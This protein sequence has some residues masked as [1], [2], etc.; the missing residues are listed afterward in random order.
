MT[1]ATQPSERGPEVSGP[2]LASSSVND[3]SGLR[4]EFD[5]ARSAFPDLGPRLDKACSRRLEMAQATLEELE[6]RL[7]AAEDPDEQER[8]Q[9]LV[10]QAMARRDEAVRLRE[11][12]EQTVAMLG[13]DFDRLGTLLEAGVGK[14]VLAD[15]P[16]QV[17][18]A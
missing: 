7:R 9:V 3:V 2:D 12:V 16:I 18:P 13:D 6:A 17:E 10:G 15:V 1:K 11:S 8:L 4:T 14:S 5:A